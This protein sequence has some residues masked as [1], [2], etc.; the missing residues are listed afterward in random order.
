MSN[1]SGI[2]SFQFIIYKID[3]VNF[4]TAKNTSILLMN[5]LSGQN[6]MNFEIGFRQAGKYLL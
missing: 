1:N 4:Q 3:T 5:S 6:Q 2:A